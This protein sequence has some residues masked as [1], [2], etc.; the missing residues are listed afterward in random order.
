MPVTINAV[1]KALEKLAAAGYRPPQGAQGSEMAEVWFEVLRDVNND[2]MLR[3]V[4]DYIRSG[5]PFW[6]VPG[7]IAA[8][9]NPNAYRPATM[10]Q[11][12]D[13]PDKELATPQQI[14]AAWAEHLDLEDLKRRHDRRRALNGG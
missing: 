2:R 7:V 13:D 12:N 6:P 8:M 14:R 1:A 10:W 9:T 11:Q 5:N 3:A 4:D